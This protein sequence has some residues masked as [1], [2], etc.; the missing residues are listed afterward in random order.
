MR[1][2]PD[3]PAQLVELRQAEVGRVVDDDRVGVG[4]VQPILDDGRADQHVDLARGEIEHHVLKLVLG[5]LPM[6][7]GELRLGTSRCS[8]WAIV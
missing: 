8:R 7:D 3:A 1:P 6:P 4:N 2:A 5:H